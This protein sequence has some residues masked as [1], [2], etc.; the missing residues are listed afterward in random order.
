MKNVLIT[1][2][3]SGMIYPVIQRLKD[4]YHLYVTVHTNSE[5]KSIKK[6]YKDNKNI[7]CLKLDIVSDANKIRDL[8]IDVLVLNGALAESGSLMEI[9][10][11]KV[12]E[13]F[14]VNVFSNLNL[15][16]KAIKNM[17][18]KGFGRIVIISSLTSKMPLPFLGSYSATKAALSVMARTLYYESMLLKSNVDIVL[19]EPG[20]YRTGFNKLAF[21]KKYEFMDND[22]F[23]ASQIEFIRKSENIY[24][25]LIEKR[26]LTSISNKIYKAITLEK[27][28]FRYS[29]PFSHNLVSKIFNLFY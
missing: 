21:D 26:N 22:S 4:D 9:P 14:E 29:A 18:Y 6:L 7:E 25:K 16:Q 8:D 5:L 12:R 23:F 27:P 17:I 28:R 2:A 20:L 3:R 11:E 10:L 24:L 13:N 19:V 1:G 15:I